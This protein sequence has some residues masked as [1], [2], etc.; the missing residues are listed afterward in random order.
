[1]NEGLAAPQTLT[2]SSSVCKAWDLSILKH[3]A[4]PLASL[5]GLRSKHC[6]YSFIKNLPSKRNI[7]IKQHKV[8]YQ[9]NTTCTK[10]YRDLMKTMPTQVLRNWNVPH[11]QPSTFHEENFE[12]RL[13]SEI[14]MKCTEDKGSLSCRQHLHTQ[15]RVTDHTPPRDWLP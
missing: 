3:G 12:L 8:V 13:K 1:M 9:N 6:T 5:L 2:P 10:Q 15:C 14:S 4:L 7:C 11:S